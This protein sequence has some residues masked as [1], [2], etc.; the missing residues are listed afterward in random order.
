MVRGGSNK[1]VRT[2]MAAGASLHESRHH[3]FCHRRRH[4]FVTTMPPPATYKYSSTILPFS[5][6]TITN[7]PSLLHTSNGSL[8]SFYPFMFSSFHQWL[9]LSDWAAEP[10][11]IPRQRSMATAPLPIS[12]SLSS[13]ESP[14]SRTRSPGWGGG[15][16]HWSLGPGQRWVPV[17]RRQYDPPYNPAQ[18]SAS[19]WFL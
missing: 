9:P 18:R 12:Q 7:S 19:S 6:T 14:S 10:L 17:R 11:G 4:P 13:W 16:F 8:F 3:V 2:G 1:R 5:H 15:R